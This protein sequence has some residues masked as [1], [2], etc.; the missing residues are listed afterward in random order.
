M[1]LKVWGKLEQK[2]MNDFFTEDEKLIYEVNTIASTPCSYHIIRGCKLCFGTSPTLGKNLWKI[3]EHFSKKK[4]I[5]QC[6]RKING[7]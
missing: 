6:S 3:E 5:A 4:K 2:K 7:F 1:I